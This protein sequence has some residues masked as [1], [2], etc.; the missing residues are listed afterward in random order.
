M[1]FY[2]LPFFFIVVSLITGIV[3]E[4][5]FGFDYILLIALL[6][7]AILMIF[8]NFRWR[9]LLSLS[10][11]FTVLGSII[12]D[13]NTLEVN[14][15]GESTVVLQIIET[16]TS[17]REW[18]Q[19]I[20]KVL[21]IRKN[22]SY[23]STDQKILFYTNSELIEDRMKIMALAD[24][25]K[26]RNSNNPGSF[27]AERYW[28]S[29]GIG[30]MTFITDNDFRVI[31][32]ESPGLFEKFSSS[33]R[34]YIV[35][36]LENSF[37][38]DQAAVLK[39]LLLG[40]KGDLSTEIQT[41]FSNAGA[42][43]LLAVSGLHVG[44]IAMI[45]LFMFRQFPKRI[46]NLWAHILVVIILWLYA[47]VTGFSPSVTRAVLMF[48]LLILS[49]LA[50]GQYEPINVLFF[51][52]FI[53][54]IWN[55][56]VIYDIGFQLSYLAVL[57]I[58]LFYQKLESAIYIQSKILKWLWQGTSV[59]LAAQVTTAPL[60]LY[61]FHQFPNYFPLSNL[62]VMLMA[63]VLMFTSILFLISFKLS[64][65][66]ALVVYALSLMVSAL[67]YFVTWVDL[68]PWSVARGFEVNSVQVAIY[69]FGIVLILFAKKKRLVRLIGVG[70]IALFIVW[71]QFDRYQHLTSDHLIV[72]NSRI[73]IVL[74]KEGGHTVCITTQSELSTGD[75]T[76]LRDYLKIYPSKLRMELL[77]PGESLKLSGKKEHCKFS[78]SST[79]MNIKKGKEQIDLITRTNSTFSENGIRINMPYL[80][81]ESG[82][83]L[84]SGAYK[85]QF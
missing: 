16:K 58:F 55:P 7:A 33:V 59:G 53:V 51:S 21:Y 15:L 56:N 19:G 30:A 4:Y 61:Y 34:S 75:E 28:R 62:G 31:A 43:H 18:K 50:P 9:A 60:A 84:K 39:A 23:T 68:L 36:A 82:Y 74:L 37:S 49:R 42:M 22:G 5:E 1:S 25:M 83:S 76:A 57:G 12:A 11:L 13:S 10:L 17:K 64:P 47:S 2:K 32:K 52:C 29:K 6:T 48:S 78:L 72:L 41:H 63:G 71:I 20:A 80:N 44:I 3:L 14:A 85:M 26:I 24:L 27:N 67:T 69:V 35:T 46:S 45:L 73:P 54:V 8:F 40:D 77:K 66:K 79:G 38:S 81:E 70:L 65:L